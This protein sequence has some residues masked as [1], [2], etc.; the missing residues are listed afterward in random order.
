MATLSN[1]SLSATLST[2]RPL[3]WVFTASYD[4]IFTAQEAAGNPEFTDWIA[5][6]GEFIDSATFKPT[7]AHQPATRRHKQ[8]TT[9]S[10]LFQGVAEQQVTIRLKN[11]GL[12][13]DSQGIDTPPLLFGNPVNPVGGPT[14]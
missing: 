4:V 5:V 1:A 14:T 2:D 8:F 6:Q 7:H 10:L 13:I 12:G 3:T 11:T 9:A